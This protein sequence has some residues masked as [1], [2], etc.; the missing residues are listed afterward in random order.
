MSAENELQE[1]VARLIRQSFPTSGR[2]SLLSAY[3]LEIARNVIAQVRNH[4]NPV[5]DLAASNREMTQQQ[6]RAVPCDA[7]FAQPGE[8]CTQPT[9][10]GRRAVAWHHVSR[11]IEAAR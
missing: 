5:R 3:E 6:V 1:Q 4:D 8:P 9:V 11:I 2:T 7:C 10:M